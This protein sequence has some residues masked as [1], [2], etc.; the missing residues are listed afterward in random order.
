MIIADVAFMAQA[1]A[2]PPISARILD[3]Q[4]LGVLVAR[5]MTVR[6][7][8]STAA[9]VSVVVEGFSVIPIPHGLRLEIRTTVP[10]V[11][12]LLFPSSSLT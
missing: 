6:I 1:F 4:V 2:N 7:H 8:G 9:T 3:A 10:L 5:T 11:S 12:S